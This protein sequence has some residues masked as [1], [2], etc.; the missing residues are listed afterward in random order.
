[1]SETVFYMP[2]RVICGP[3]ALAELARA[4]SL[5]KKALLVTGKTFARKSGL[6]SR[7]QQILTDAGLDSIVFDQV[8]RDPAIPTVETAAGLAKE[9]GCDLVIGLGGG[10]AMDAAKAVAVL[11]T[12]PGSL[13]DYFGQEKLTC[14]AAPIVCVPT[15]AGTASEVTRYA[16]IVDPQAQAKMT[17]ASDLIIPQLAI[18]DASWTVALPADLTAQTGMDAFSHAVEAYLSTAGNLLSDTFCLQAMEMI[19]SALPGVLDEPENLALREKMLLASSLA[20]LALNSAG[21]II[22]HGMAYTLTIRYGM[23]H[24]LANALL[25]PY[26]IAYIAGDYPQ[27]IARLSRMLDCED[28]EIGLLDFN[29]RLNIP[30]SLSDAA[31]VRE[32]L[33]VLA[34]SCRANCVRALPRIK[35]K[36]TLDDYTKI[37]QRAF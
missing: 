25:L 13:N 33:D 5:G 35:R 14:P 27:K 29:Q 1:M 18:L 2:G 17:I 21:T 3:N 32:D 8:E 24:G 30:T 4:A 37:L 22:N 31:V 10:S 11:L 6:L 26:T 28:I 9:H 36:M 12:N 15:T 23:G 19:I 7:S 34:Q 20:G 16:V